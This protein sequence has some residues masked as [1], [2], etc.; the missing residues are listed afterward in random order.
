MRRA[1]L[2]AIGLVAACCLL[3]VAP[4]VVAADDL[5]TARHR[6]AAIS[7]RDWIADLFARLNEWLGWQE[8]QA[9]RPAVE[10]VGVSMDGNGLRPAPAATDCG[11]GLD[12]GGTPCAE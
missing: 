12:P 4:A 2:I 5:L 7:P 9:P 11:L 8:Q 10:A 6:P 3:L 1:R